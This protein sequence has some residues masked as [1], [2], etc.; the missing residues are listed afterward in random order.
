MRSSGVLSSRLL[1]RATSKEETSRDIL[2]RLK[3]LGCEIRSIDKVV[4]EPENKL[5]K[6]SVDLW[7]RRGIL[8]NSEGVIHVKFQR[9]RT[10]YSYPLDFDVG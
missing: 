9:G 10:W 7:R 8:V 2:E 6:G 4:V 3:L 1:S 5:P